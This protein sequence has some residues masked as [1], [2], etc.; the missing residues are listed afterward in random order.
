MKTTK[1]KSLLML[2]CICLCLGVG[3][4]DSDDNSTKQ[5]N[6]IFYTNAQAM[7]NCGPFDVD[8]YIDDE[9]IGTI[10][11]PFVE[12]EEPDCVNTSETLMVSKKAGKYNYTAKMDCGQDGEWTGEFQ[13]IHD[14]CLRIFL[15]IEDCNIKDE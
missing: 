4:D 7:L 14:S 15:D 9:L 8:V 3:C 1:L 10:S 6:V 2:L 11:E 5:G 13:I 12:D